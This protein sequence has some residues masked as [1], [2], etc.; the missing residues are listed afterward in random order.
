MSDRSRAEDDLVGQMRYYRLS[1]HSRF[2]E[3][4]REWRFA[5]PRQWR[6]DFAWPELMVAC[7]VEGGIWVKPR[8]G[9]QGGGGHNRGKA[10]LDDMEKYSEAA[11]RGWMVIRVDPDAVKNGKALTLIL[12]ALAR[13]MKVGIRPFERICQALLD[14]DPQEAAVIAAQTWATPGAFDRGGPAPGNEPLPWAQP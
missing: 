12:R 7:E 3:P 2:P 10:F 4:V 11:I 14:S 8:E 6:F 1:G 5:P 9:E 13:A